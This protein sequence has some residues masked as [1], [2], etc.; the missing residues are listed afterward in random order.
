MFYIYTINV[1]QGTGTKFLTTDNQCKEN[2]VI[3]LVKKLY[4]A[5]IKIFM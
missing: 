1:L 2:N 3:R 4:S 5:I